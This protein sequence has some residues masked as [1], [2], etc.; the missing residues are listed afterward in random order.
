MR[1]LCEAS[2]DLLTF[3]SLHFQWLTS[4]CLDQQKRSKYDVIIT[5][6]ERFIAILDALYF[7]FSS[8]LFIQPKSYENNDLFF[9]ALSS[10][11]GNV[12]SKK[13]VKTIA[14][15]SDNFQVK[16]VLLFVRFGAF[17]EEP[18]NPFSWKFNQWITTRGRRLS[19]VFVR[20]VSCKLSYCFAFD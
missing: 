19:K 5:V 1:S 13:K 17:L 9:T 3:E 20:K 7:D 8:C 4:W 16:C 2:F 15:S 14:I 12:G 11:S 6:L 10:Y 18:A